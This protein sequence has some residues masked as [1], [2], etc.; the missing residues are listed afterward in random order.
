MASEDFNILQWSCMGL[1]LFS[2]L[3][4][5]G[6][7]IENVIFPIVVHGKINNIQVWNDVINCTKEVQ[8]EE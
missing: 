1:L 5:T 4:R 8:L 3:N 7:W 6:R 2:K